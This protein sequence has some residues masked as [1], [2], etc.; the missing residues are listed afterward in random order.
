MV[1][2]RSEFYA[3]PPLKNALGKT[4]RP[5]ASAH[6]ELW[7]WPCGIFVAAKQLLGGPLSRPHHAGASGQLDGTSLRSQATT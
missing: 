4:F 2:N 7:G 5:L 1:T 3:L 6:R